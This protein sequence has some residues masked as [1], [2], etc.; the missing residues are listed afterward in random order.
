MLNYFSVGSGPHTP[1]Q[2]PDLRHIPG[3]I[4]KQVSDTVL[5]TLANG[6]VVLMTFAWKLFIYGPTIR[7]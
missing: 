4:G 6:K 7:Y 3:D 5:V 1:P 2:S